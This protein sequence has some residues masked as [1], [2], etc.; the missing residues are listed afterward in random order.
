MKLRLII[1]KFY[2]FY[3]LIFV[4]KFSI[5]IDSKIYNYVKW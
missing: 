3:I 2:I 4:N 5:F 1:T